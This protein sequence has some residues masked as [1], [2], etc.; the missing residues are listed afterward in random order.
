MFESFRNGCSSGSG[1]IT[2]KLQK[3]VDGKVTDIVFSDIKVGDEIS[4]SCGSV[5]MAGGPTSVS[6]NCVEVSFVGVKPSLQRQSAAGNCEESTLNTID[7]DIISLESFYK[8]CPEG[9]LR[10]LSLQKLEDTLIDNVRRAGVTER[11]VLTDIQPTKEAEPVRI[12][13]QNIDTAKYAFFETRVSNLKDDNSSLPWR[14]VIKYNFPF[15]LK[16]ESAKDRIKIV[17]A[18]P[19]VAFGNGSIVRF[20]DDVPFPLQQDE[21]N[22][23]GML[24]FEGLLEYQDPAKEEEKILGMSTKI[25]NSRVVTLRPILNSV[26]FKGDKTDPLTFLLL[27]DMGLVYLHGKGSLIKTDGTIVALPLKSN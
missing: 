26:V 23:S 6:C 5:S 3:V 14:E 16:M 17:G 8:K 27:S 15:M 18:S 12:T 25:T 21:I 10:A 22:R 13:I 4:A 11:F 19:D 1:A 20:V 24:S 2:T 7:K 9:K